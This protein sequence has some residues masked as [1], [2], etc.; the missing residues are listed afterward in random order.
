[1]IWIDLSYVL[2]QIT[3]LIDKQTTF[4]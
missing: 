2:S 1:M 3:H 4:S